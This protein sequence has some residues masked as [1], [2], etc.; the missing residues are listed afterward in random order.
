MLQSEQ[1][2]LSEVGKLATPQERTAL[3]QEIA[4]QNFA[5]YVGLLSKVGEN[6]SQSD[7]ERLVDALGTTLQQGSFQSSSTSPM[8][9]DNC[10]KATMP[11]Y[12]R[13]SS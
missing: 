11:H 5:F 1:A 12:A 4:R 3:L 9:A 6:G 2:L 10:G 8:P 13:C 7:K